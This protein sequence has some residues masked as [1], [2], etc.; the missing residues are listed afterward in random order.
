LKPQ[1][2]ARDRYACAGMPLRGFNLN[3]LPRNGVEVLA[4]LL[5]VN[6]LEMTLLRLRKMRYLLFQCHL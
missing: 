5:E 2:F 1:L 3:T 6:C 4:L